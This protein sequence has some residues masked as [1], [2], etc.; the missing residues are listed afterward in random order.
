MLRS[1]ARLAP[2]SK[3]TNDRPVPSRAGRFA[4]P[5]WLL[6]TG[7]V[8]VAIVLVIALCLT[9]LITR[10]QRLDVALH[11]SVGGTTTVIVG[12][13]DRSFA[14]EGTT[15]FGQLDAD[16]GARADIIFA[17][18][19]DRTGKRAA[20][21]SRDFMVD[22]SDTESDRLAT[23][24]QRG[25]QA[26]VDGLCRGLHMPVDQ[27]LV[28][29]LRGFV[30]AVDALGGVEVT[31]PYPLRDSMAHIDLPA[32]TQLLDGATALGY[33]RSRQGE[34]QVDGQWIADP[35]GS[36]GRQRRAAEV[37]TAVMAEIPNNPIEL[38]GLAYELLPEMSIDAHTD[39][40]D[41]LELRNLPTDLTSVPYKG[42]VGPDDWLVFPS[43]ETHTTLNQLGLAGDCP[44]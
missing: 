33:V 29:N 8:L 12:I 1:R 43:E 21:I 32:G 42:G 31:L 39:V 19:S 25:P 44:S 34:I 2:V 15:D 28:V 37:L 7:T 11:P 18:R 5:G 40:L 16:P 17:I 23:A 10:P 35:E 24:W 27:L 22:I 41:L 30:K 9:V 26:F 36:L 4:L 6:A 38:Y 14:P 3:T 20:S 13:D